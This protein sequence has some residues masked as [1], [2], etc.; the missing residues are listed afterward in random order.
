MYLIFDTET[1][2]LPKDWKQPFTNTDNWPRLVQLAWQLHDTTGKLISNQNFIIKPDG[3]EI[4]YAVSKVHGITTERAYK[5]GIDLKIALE[6]FHKD[7]QQAKYNVGHN[8]EFDVNVM[9]CEFFRL[10]DLEPLVTT[11]EAI[12]TKDISTEWCALPGGRGGKFKWPT[13]TELHT[14]LFGEG[15]WRCARCSI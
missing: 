13:L 2:G 11:L 1:T 6:A 15:F 9:G 8:I 5:D 4:P 12:D 10:G 14:K 3:F 7:L